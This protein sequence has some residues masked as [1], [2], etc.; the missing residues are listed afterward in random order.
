MNSPRKHVILGAGGAISRVLAPELL[1]RTLP[2]K[3]V[4]R[5]G[6]ALDGA[7][8]ATADLMDPAQ[9]AAVVD[10]NS[11]VYLLAG[12]PYR[13]AIWREQW[14]K[15]MSNVIN[16]CKHKHARLVFFDN[17][18]ALGKVNGPMT[19]ETPMNPCSKKGEVRAMITENLIKEWKAGNLD[20]LIARAADFYGPHATS[21]S[22]PYLLVIKRL[23]AGQR[24]QGMVS[25]DTKHSYTYTVDCGK[26]LADLA[27]TKD[28][29]NQLWNLPTAAPA[30][31]GIEYVQMVAD[32]LEVEPRSTVLSKFMM[33]LGGMVSGDIK[34]LH[35]MLYQN[36]FDYVFDSSK[37]DKRFGRSAIS[38]EM[39][40]RETIAFFRDSG[41]LG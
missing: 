40:I 19:E 8:S 26:A 9:T 36:E 33:R 23:A 6:F 21:V 18:Y 31:I 15:I 3:L 12:L 24:A 5:S 27:T 14:P 38:Y 20:A 13:T 7:E 39:G 25:L 41:D 4:S 22:V 32:A 17:V 34:E 2:T 28:S 30:P 37:F 35:E 1:S 10:E 16:A 29:Y 11:I